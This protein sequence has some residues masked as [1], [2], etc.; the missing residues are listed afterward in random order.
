MKRIIKTIDYKLYKVNK[1]HPSIKIISII[2]LSIVLSITMLVI[3][4]LYAKWDARQFDLD[5][6]ISTPQLENDIDINNFNK[7]VFI[8]LIKISGGTGEV[9]KTYHTKK[10]KSLSMDAI[11]DLYGSEK[12][13]NSKQYAIS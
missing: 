12:I 10:R 7:P 2:V 3:S 5:I 11:R 6:N 9:L 1:K 13:N 8:M 4:F